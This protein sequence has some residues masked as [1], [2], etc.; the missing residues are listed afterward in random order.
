MHTFF[1]FLPIGLTNNH[2]RQPESSFLQLIFFTYMFYY[3]PFYLINKTNHSLI[4][5]KLNIDILCK[6]NE[7]ITEAIN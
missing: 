3:L 7:V 4:K 5:F 1:G 2:R 6:L